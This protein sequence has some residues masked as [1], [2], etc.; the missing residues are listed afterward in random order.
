MLS[1]WQAPEVVR[2]PRKAHPLENK[3]VAGLQYGPSAD[4]WA[5]G[6]LAFELITGYVPFAG[7]S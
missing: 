3:E 2:C 1:S 4:V 5:V 6:V 7:V